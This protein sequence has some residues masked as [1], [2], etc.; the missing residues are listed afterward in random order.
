MQMRLQTEA[1]S[2]RR[3]ALGP[4]LG[5]WG[6]LCENKPAPE[7]TQRRRVRQR[8]QTADD[9]MTEPTNRPSKSTTGGRFLKALDA[10]SQTL[11]K[12]LDRLLEV[13]SPIAQPIPV[14]VSSRR[15]G[16]G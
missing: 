12:S 6:S 11:I 10:M 16:Q 4:A 7:L 1:C 15:R 3:I 14:R 9:A 8:Y 2:V 13:G 5:P